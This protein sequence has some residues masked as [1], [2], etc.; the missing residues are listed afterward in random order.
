MLSKR[1]PLRYFA[2]YQSSGVVLGIPISLKM[3]S[4]LGCA[5]RGLWASCCCYNWASPLMIPK[6]PD[7]E[8]AALTVIR[9]IFIVAA[10]QDWSSIFDKAMYYFHSR[11]GELRRISR[12]HRD[13]FMP[14]MSTLKS[15]SPLAEYRKITTEITRLMPD[16]QK[17]PMAKAEAVRACRAQPSRPKL[18]R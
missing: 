18:P 2:N 7:Q 10:R 16:E 5:N 13:P 3:A 11:I 14:I 8:I 17:Y 6:R 4:T 15:D 9:A 12:K 1:I